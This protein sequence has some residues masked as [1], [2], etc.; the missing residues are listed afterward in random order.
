M[1][2]Y[3][4]LLSAVNSLTNAVRGC[5]AALYMIFIV[6]FLKNMNSESAIKSLKD[7][8]H[9]VGYRVTEQVEYLKE[10]IRKK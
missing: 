9:N 2:D 10:V 4:E 7:E 1:P 3:T 8:L 6:L 5:A